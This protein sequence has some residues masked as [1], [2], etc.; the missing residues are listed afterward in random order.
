MLRDILDLYKGLENEKQQEQGCP[1]QLVLIVNVTLLHD[2]NAAAAELSKQC[3]CC[4][5]VSDRCQQSEIS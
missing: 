4:V 3:T 5:E 1:G 2:K